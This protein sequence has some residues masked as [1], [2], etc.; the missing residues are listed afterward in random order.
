MAPKKTEDD[1][2]TNPIPRSASFE[3]A[4]DA[5][6]A[7]GDLKA[8][9]GPDP[10][11][12]ETYSFTVEVY[13]GDGK[14]VEGSGQFTNKILTVQDRVDIGLTASKIVRH[15]PWQVLDPET[16]ETVL[17]GAHLSLSLVE[18]P[19]KFSVDKIKNTRLLQRVWQEVESHEVTFRGSDAPQGTGPSRS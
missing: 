14:L 17:I 2:P 12:S 9:K 1:V 16:Q 10:R 11:A 4:A 15:L 7:G 5:V 3:E 19:D 13:G 6:K 8:T 18:R